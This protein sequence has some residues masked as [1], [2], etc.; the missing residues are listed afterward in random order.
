[1]TSKRSPSEARRALALFVVI[2]LLILWFGIQAF[3]VIRNESLPTVHSWLSIWDQ[4][5]APHYLDIARDGYVTEG[6]A[7]RWI[8]F[9]PLFPWLTRGV[10]F[11]VGDALVSAFIVSTIASL[12]IAWLLFKLVRLDEDDEIA[13]ESVWFLSIFPAAY[14]LHIGYTEPVFIALVL[15]SFFAVR[16][17]RWAAAGILG[18]LASL[19]RINGAFMVPALAV[20]AWTEYRT[21]RR[22]EMRWLWALVAGAGTLIYLWVNKAVTGDW[23]TFRH[24]Q[25]DHWN[26]TFTLPLMAAVDAWRGIWLRPPSE[27]I[28]VGWQEF[29]FTAITVAATVWSWMRQRPSYALWA[30]LNIALFTSVGLLLGAPRYSLAI[31]PIFTCFARI[32]RERPVLRALIIA[33]S[34]LFLALFAGQFVTQ[35]WAF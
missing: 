19:T 21:T 18:A 5:D 14:F 11:A 6:E 2:K 27:S 34:L 23:F 25:D 7:R 26:H 12:F 29:L 3:I 31:F 10:N 22:F 16:R 28:M 30:T 13:R 32:T 17:G 1:M 8:V 20:E 35:K 15:G 33:W 9:F 24:Y 4:W